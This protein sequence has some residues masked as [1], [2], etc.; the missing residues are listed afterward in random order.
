MSASDVLVRTNEAPRFRITARLGDLWRHREILG[1]LARKELRVK[2]KSTILGVAWSMLHPLLYL[3]VFY[4]VFTYFLPSG[5]P[6][7]PVYLLSGL[8]PWTLFST[9]L[10]GATASVTGN[11]QLVPKVAFPREVLPL[12]VIRA[13]TV[14][15]FFQFLVL[16]GFLVVF[17]YPLVHRGLILLPLALA[18]LL[19]F[20]AAVGFATAALNVRY[21]DVTYLVELGLLAW[22]WGTPI[23][24][25]ASLVA[26]NLGSTG[27]SIY[28]LNPVTNIV[29][30]FQRAIYGGVSSEA[31]GELPAPGLRWY[32]FRALAVGAV[33][34]ALLYVT[35]RLFFRRSGDFAEEL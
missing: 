1:N 25:P 2:Y 31:L 35:W 34:A 16:V 11:A 13:Q 19:L 27:F 4:V 33:S 18:V 32:G 9:A 14:N 22:F 8:L 5:I 20:V 28:L 10:G 12:A 29:L 24:Y 15:F 3:V 21:R 23:V 26:D 17:G 6:D 30:T 7:F